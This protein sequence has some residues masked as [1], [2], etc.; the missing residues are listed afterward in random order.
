MLV[1][2]MLWHVFVMYIQGTVVDGASS[3]LRSSTT[4]GGGLQRCYPAFATSAASSSY[5]PHLRRSLPTLN[6]SMAAAMSAASAEP[7]KLYP[8]H[9]LVTSNY[10]LPADVDRLNLE[11]SCYNTS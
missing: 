10:R 11:V 4:F 9:L 1:C 5:S 3:E 2:D 8:Y 7:P 6:H